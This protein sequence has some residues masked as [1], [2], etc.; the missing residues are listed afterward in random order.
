MS[1]GRAREHATLFT[2]QNYT[3]TEGSKTLDPLYHQLALEEKGTNRRP[4]HSS[5]KHWV[6]CHVVYYISL[7]FAAV[8][9]VVVYLPHRCSLSPTFSLS[10]PLFCDCSSFQ[11]C[12]PLFRRD[13][14]SE[15]HSR[16]HW[17]SFISCRHGLPCIRLHR[18]RC[19]HRRPGGRNPL[20]RRCRQ[21]RAA[22]RGRCESHGGPENGN[23]RLFD[24]FVWR[25]RLRLGF[26]N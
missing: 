6:A 23:S 13:Q 24:H 21:E 12:H 7:L 11:L 18:C 16:R 9:V 20:E 1:A 14:S 10:S 25:P 17:A 4:R 2:S 8:V 5:P 19:G 22:D 15:Q 3:W 26:H